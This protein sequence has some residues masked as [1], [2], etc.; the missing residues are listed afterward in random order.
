MLAALAGLGGFVG[1]FHHALDP[2]KRLTLPSEW[3]EMVGDPQRLFVLP[4]VNEACLCVYPARSMALR[5]EKLRNFSIADEKGRQFLRALASRSLHTGW[6]AQGRFRL[7]EDLLEYAGIGTQA[8]LV[9]CLESFELWSPERW[10]LRKS[11][12]MDGYLE[13]AKY[14]GL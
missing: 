4:G 2:K 11:Q 13:A 7:R 10:Q 9:G 3:R 12:D 6:D 1:T 8:V 5:L 14:V